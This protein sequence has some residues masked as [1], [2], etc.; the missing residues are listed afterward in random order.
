MNLSTYERES[1]LWKKLEQHLNERLTT[2]RTRND[3]ELDAIET[4]RLRGRISQVK[5][6]L[7]LSEAPEHIA[8]EPQ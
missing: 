6:F 8:D 5:E 3:G 4:A 7:A 1:A 2:L